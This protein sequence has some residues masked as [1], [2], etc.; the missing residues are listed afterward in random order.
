MCISAV[1]CRTAKGDDNIS[2]KTSHTRP[3]SSF[4]VIYAINL[5]T[6]HPPRTES[7]YRVSQDHCIRVSSPPNDNGR[8]RRPWVCATDKAI[9]STIQSIE[10]KVQ[11]EDAVQQNQ[12]IEPHA[13]LNDIKP[14]PYFVCHVLST[15]PPHTE[16]LPFPRDFPFQHQPKVAYPGARWRGVIHT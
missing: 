5:P 15:H 7:S 2:C 3:V 8:F 12:Q 6:K 16:P 13:P 4:G 11:V 1:D 14:I 9:L 10:L